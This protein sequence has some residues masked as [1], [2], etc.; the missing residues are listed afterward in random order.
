MARR[1]NRLSILVAALALCAPIT[2]DGPARAHEVKTGGLKIVHPWVRATP[3]GVS[4][5]AG[6]AKIKNA[7][8]AADRLLSATLIRAK[9][10]EV[11]ETTVDNGI[12]RMR[13]VAGGIEIKPGATV[14][15]KPG[16]LHLMFIGLD[17]G[18][19]EHDYVAGT[20][21]FAKAGTIKVEFA[22]EA[23]AAGADPYKD[24]K[25]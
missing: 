21:T 24:H 15:L 12:A 17:E 9:S 20:M 8:K 19:I 22:V 13:P 10:T 2:S 18:L 16:G 1:K 11:H 7:G 4:V 6:Y 3:K 14:E 5:T 25:H 23:P